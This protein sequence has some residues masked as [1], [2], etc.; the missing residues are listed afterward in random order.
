MDLNFELMREQI[1]LHGSGA[2][3][4]ASRREWHRADAVMIRRI[5]NHNF[6]ARSPFPPVTA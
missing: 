2:A 6:G 1:A 5:I 3:R 4:S